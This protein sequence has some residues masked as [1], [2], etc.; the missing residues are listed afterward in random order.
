MELE[1]VK[2]SK[3]RDLFSKNIS[4]ILSLTKDRTFTTTQLSK[5]CKELKEKGLVA[6]TFSH[7]NLVTELSEYLAKHIKIEIDGDFQ[8]IFSYDKN[9]GVDRMLLGFKKNSFYS[10]SS[11]LYILNISKFRGEFIFISQELSKKNGSHIKTTLTQDAIDSAFKKDY[12]R[13]QKIGKY[14]EK[15][16]VFL[17]PKHTDYFEV[18]TREDGVRH[19]SIHRAFVEM[20]VNVQY[21]K[22]SLHIIDTFKPLKSKLDLNT[23]FEVLKRFDF[24]YPYFQCVGFYLEQ[25][26]FSKSEL[27]RFKAEV[28][29]LKFYTDKKM[30]SYLYDEYWKIYYIEKGE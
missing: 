4:I 12:R 6:Q 22:D 10:M 9:I 19:S 28:G 27:E 20:I 7:Y 16:L 15:Y 30:D 1:L 23:V 8:S 26:G 13:T 18:V 3:R 11:A 25:I 5:F 17:Y 29:E 2:I 21:F 24:I 14:Q